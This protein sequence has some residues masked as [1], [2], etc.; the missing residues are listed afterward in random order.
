MSCE[1]S[2]REFH[3]HHPL[4]TAAGSAGPN[5]P[6]AGKLQAKQPHWRDKPPGTGPGLAKP[7]ILLPEMVKPGMAGILKPLLNRELEVI[8]L[9][10]QK[11][12]FKKQGKKNSEEN[13]HLTRDNR[14]EE[15]LKS[16]CKL[17]T[18]RYQFAL[19][20]NLGFL[21]LNYAYNSLIIH[22]GIFT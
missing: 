4:W 13:Q 14:W 7:P 9:Q 1:V 21:K 16:P 2:H 12:A 3:Q 5:P 17:H 6:Q 15:G 22:S 11:Q 20:Q 8:W 18:S 10:T 19:Q